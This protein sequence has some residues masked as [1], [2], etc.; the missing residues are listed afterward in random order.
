[1]TFEVGFAGV[2]GLDAA[3]GR[4]PVVVGDRAELGAWDP[5][6][7]DLF[8]DGTHGDRA[9]GD[10]VWSRTVHLAERGQVA[11]KYLLRNPGGDPWAGVEFGGDNRQQ[12]V[13]DADDTG[14]V[15]LRDAFGVRGGALLDW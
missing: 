4:T 6:V 5:T 10:Q 1:V 11:Y 15:R 7:V 8:D 2:A 14:R 12:W 3:A 9:A 13:Q